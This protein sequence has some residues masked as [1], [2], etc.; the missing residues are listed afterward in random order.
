M[1]YFQYILALIYL[2]KI[3][4]HAPWVMYLD[5][6]LVCFTTATCVLVCFVV[7]IASATLAQNGQQSI[8]GCCRWAVSNWID[9][10]RKKNKFNMTRFSE[11][12]ANFFFLLNFQS[13]SRWKR[14]W[15]HSQSDTSAYTPLVRLGL[16]WINAG[17][18]LYWNW[19]ATSTPTTNIRNWFLPVSLKWTQLVEVG[20]GYHSNGSTHYFPFLETYWPSTKINHM[21]VF[22]C[23]SVHWYMAHRTEMGILYQPNHSHA[24]LLVSVM[25]KSFH[26]YFG[27]GGCA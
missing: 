3:W 14:T 17:V 13:I 22:D 18:L 27:H 20:Q 8:L 25:H 7:G 21:P 12:T 1:S 26:A 23:Q 6:F 5:I 19:H 2:S 16:S 4:A 24:W 15:N 9:T 10:D 11:Y